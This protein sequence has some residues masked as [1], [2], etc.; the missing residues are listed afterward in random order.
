[1]QRIV[2]ATAVLFFAIGLGNANEVESIKR[3]LKS[4]ADSRYEGPVDGLKAFVTTRADRLEAAADRM[5]S[6][7]DLS[8][9]DRQIA[10]EAQYWGIVQHFYAEPEKTVGRLRDSAE[11]LERS[12]KDDA[13]W[14][15]KFR[16]LYLRCRHFQLEIDPSVEGFKS[17]LDEYLPFL[18]KHPEE[19]EYMTSNVVVA[20]FSS[21]F[22][23]NLANTTDPNRSEGLVALL[24]D[25]TKPILEKSKRNS[26][27][28]QVIDRL[29]TAKKEADEG[30]PPTVWS[31]FHVSKNLPELRDLELYHYC[32]QYGDG[33][34]GESLFSG[35]PQLEVA[36]A[37]L[38]DK[39]LSGEERQ[40]VLGWKHSALMSLVFATLQKNFN[41]DLDAA[42]A[43]LDR[44]LTEREND[45]ETDKWHLIYPRDSFYESAA[46]YIS[47]SNDPLKAY[48]KYSQDYLEFLDKYAEES[49]DH[50]RGMAVTWFLG[51]ALDLDPNGELGFLKSFA[52]KVIPILEKKPE[53]V[54]KF[55][56]DS[57]KNRL[58]DF[59]KKLKQIGND[60]EFE[61]VL[62]D[63]SR[64][65]IE[66]LK[67]KVVLVTFWATWCGPCTSKFPDLLETY[68]KY[69]D[70]GFDVVAYSWDKDVD[71]LRKYEEKE[72]H[73]WLVGSFKLSTEAGLKNYFE[74]NKIRGIPASFLINGKGKIIAFPRLFGKTFHETLEKYLAL[75]KTTSDR[76]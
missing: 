17:L 20:F 48:R 57:A 47:R 15:D 56:L 1:M 51:V 52:E 3:E 65:K 29:D 38:A 33:S 19:K 42:V 5:L 24:V 58:A 45:P 25:K 69:R 67:G 37:A 12:G 60:F 32:L 43:P 61:T 49:S 40:I 23:L 72:K 22:L 14:I 55:Q 50:S 11:R 64:L 26:M 44:F 21:G 36:E 10:L 31:P 62:L 70:Q 71:Q 54:L 2:L 75:E 39:R 66:D 8:E 30:K 34:I 18:E 59:E 4:I 53:N 68:E 73:P 46:Q 7:P 9:D 27:I 76:Q 13:F 63:G 41:G 35:N 74:H 6:L 16:F 28:A